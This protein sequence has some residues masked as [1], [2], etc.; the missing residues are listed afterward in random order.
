MH[1]ELDEVEIPIEALVVPSIGGNFPDKF[2]GC[3]AAPVPESELADP[4]FRHPKGV[5]LLVGAGVWSEITLPQIKKF[6]SNSKLLAQQTTLGF[7][8]FGQSDEEGIGRCSFHMSLPSNNQDSKLD[9]MLVK[10]WNAD[11]IPTKRKLT[12]EE[13]RAEQNF[14][15]TFKRD[16]SG[17]YVVTIPRKHDARPLG[18][19][20]KLA[21]ACF[22]NVEKKMQKLPELKKK[23]KEVM[24]DYIKCGHMVKV[25]P[26]RRVTEETYYLP[27]HPINHTS[28]S[29]GKFRVVFNASAPSSNGVSFNDQ[30]LAGPKMQ[31]DLIDIFIKFR[32]KRYGMTA[33][34]K[35][36]FRQVQIAPSEWNHQRVFW[37]ENPSLPLQ[38]YVITV[39][40]W[41]MASAGFNSVR[42]LRQCGIDGEAQ[43]PR[44]AAIA[45]GD[46]YF[47][48]MLSGAHSEQELLKAKDEVTELLAGA[49][50]ELA[51]WAT[52]SKILAQK[53]K[54][55]DYDVPLECGLLGMAWNTKRDSLRLK[56]E[57]IPALTSALTKRA[58][59]SA[60]AKVYDPSGLI[61]PV[62]VTGKILQQRIWRVDHLGWDD[63]IPEELQEQWFQ[64][65][66]NMRQLDQ[67]EI[68]RWL[69]MTPGVP[70]ELHIF[71]D[72]SESAM[73]AVAH[74]V[75]RG[76]DNTSIRIITSRSKVAPIKKLTIPCLELSAAVMGVKLAPF[77]KEA[78]QLGSIPTYFWSDSQIVIHWINR[79]PQALE[80]FVANRVAVIQELSDKEQWKHISGIDNPA[81][82]LTRG[83]TTEE[84]INS[85]LWWNG[86]HWLKFPK[87]QWEVKTVNIKIPAPPAPL[88]CNLISRPTIS[89]K[90]KKGNP[91]SRT[92]LTMPTITI[93]SLDGTEQ[94]L[95]NKT[96]GL[97]KLLRITAYVHRFI[98]KC[99]KRNTNIVK[100]T[101]TFSITV[102]EH[103]RAL[104]FWIL[105]SQ[106]L[107]FAKEIKVL[108]ENKCVEKNSS[109]YKLTPCLGKD[110]YLRMTGRLKNSQLSART[111][112]QI[113]LPPQ[114]RLAHLI[115]DHFHITTLHGGPQ[116][117][118]GQIR[119]TYWINRLRQITKSIIRRCVRCARFAKINNE[120]LMGQLPPERVT[121]GEA[122]A[123]TGVDFAG[124]FPISRAPG[125]P[126]RGSNTGTEKAWL[127]IFVCMISRAVHVEILCG[128]AVPE[129]L[130]AFERFTMRKGRCFQLFSDNGTTFVG[131]DNELA[132]VLKEWASNFPTREL[133]HN[134]T[135][136][137]FITPAAPFKGGLW[138]A[139]VKSF[140]Y[141][142]K[143][144]VGSQPM[145]K[146]ALTQIAIQIEGCLNSRPLWPLSDDPSDMQVITPADLFLGKPILAQPLA[147]Y[148]SEVPKNRLSWWEQRQKLHQQLWQQWQND[149]LTSLQ[150]RGKWFRAEVNIKVNDMVIIRDDNL[151][152]TQW[153]IGR[154]IKTYPAKD[155]LV[156]SVR[157]KTMNNELD[158]PITKV[159][160]L[161]PPR[162]VIDPNSTVVGGG[163][164]DLLEHENMDTE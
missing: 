153:C 123:R 99:K 105:H 36:M 28:N 83:A 152:P 138:E 161:I 88:R 44:G 158:R 63:E 128:L 6:R 129:F 57:K 70:L 19:S 164:A 52:N 22:M 131:T 119:Q 33:D 101:S 162:N 41:G 150:T 106:R 7:V 125:R 35:Q 80:V 146:D 90:S 108:L 21:L 84:L 34:I 1:R 156:R 27:H 32:L 71:T 25:E 122:F 59:I 13:E 114:S 15:N 62:V 73:G 92:T 4:N 157:I 23:Y 49:G 134:N 8:V 75:A 45:L 17:R 37:R 95:L 117:V 29:T 143:R 53:M 10:Y 107:F 65:E 144:I 46:F 81:D 155:G 31:S 109:I 64:F 5:G 113:I 96:S 121:I 127:C 50:F 74:L 18:N 67:V 139:A 77:I 102:A 40:S 47:D 2:I 76:N 26:S 110:G 54:N 20:H 154:I 55:D 38:E 160:V 66:N 132:R 149:Y 104:S 87:S 141:H 39:V 30:Q 72:A 85:K 145:S 3:G 120:Q 93:S 151:P 100:G 126:T 61:L 86:P 68:P 58:V 51:K 112:Q 16:P 98:D 147:E 48:D 89:F 137:T 79:N 42:A 148:V 43:Y 142:L 111:K 14:I 97:D 103:K 116:L 82:M 78:L 56:T 118:I 115:V 163:E 124:P 135:E 11:D 130:A 133:N 69:G 136:W 159:A 94:S 12:A 60:I 9:E 140:K 91:V 24:D